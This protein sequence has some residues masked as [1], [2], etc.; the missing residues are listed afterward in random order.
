M[1]L[2]KTNR[3][4]RLDCLR[5]PSSLMLMEIWSDCRNTNGVVMAVDLDSSKFFLALVCFS[6]S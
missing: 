5:N 4:W 2:N 3:R 6:K 1:K